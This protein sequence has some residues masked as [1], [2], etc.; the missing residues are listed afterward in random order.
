MNP[1]LDSDFLKN[2]KKVDIRIRKSFKERII[3]FSKN[4]TDPQLKN[5]ALRGQ[6]EGYRSIDITANY[7]AVYKEVKIGEEPVA[8]FSLLGTHEELY[9]KRN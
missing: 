8:Y 5:H 7:R 2:L 1:V 9:G 3:L 4:P 6:Y